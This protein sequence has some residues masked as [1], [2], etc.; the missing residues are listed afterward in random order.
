MRLN[1]K[2]TDSKKREIAIVVALFVN[3]IISFYLAFCLFTDS[4]IDSSIDSSTWSDNT[5]LGFENQEKSQF[6]L[7]IGLNDKHTYNQII[8][9]DEAMEI[10]NAIIIKH[11]D[12]YTMHQ[13]QGGWIDETDTLTQEDTLVY[14][15]TQIEEETVITIMDEVLIALNQNAILVESHKVRSVFYSG[16]EAQ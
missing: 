15:L 6:V 3:L 12:G 9:T 14:T 10:V 1:N 5:I 4:N 16:S 11:T 13:A 8:P 7:Y 2:R